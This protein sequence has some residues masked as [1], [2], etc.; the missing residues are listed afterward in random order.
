MILG[1]PEGKERVRFADADGNTHYPG[2]VD[3]KVTHA[4]ISNGKLPQQQN[5]GP[6]NLMVTSAMSMGAPRYNTLPHKLQQPQGTTAGGE[7]VDLLTDTDGGPDFGG[8]GSM[9]GGVQDHIYSTTSRAKPA[10]LPRAPSTNLS[11]SQAPGSSSTSA[12]SGLNKSPPP[13]NL[14]PNGPILKKSSN[15]SNT[16]SISPPVSIEGDHKTLTLKCAS[17][18]SITSV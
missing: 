6:P 9:P 17:G 4:V 3:T 5:G 1:E 16:D 18:Y 15:R 7:G 10:P 2:E 14:A 11:H 13:S 12:S 8:P